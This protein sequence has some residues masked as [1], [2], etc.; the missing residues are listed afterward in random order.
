MPAV[1]KACCN[2]EQYIRMNF[3]NLKFT[4]KKK[5]N[6]AKEKL[7]IYTISFERFFSFLHIPATF[8]FHILHYKTTIRA[9]IKLTTSRETTDCF[10]N[11]QHFLLPAARCAAIRPTWGPAELFRHSLCGSLQIHL[12][13]FTACGNRLAEAWF[14]IGYGSDGQNWTMS[15]ADY[16]R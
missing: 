16:L 7:L 6:Q 3:S 5:K 12:W 15:C 4:K 8:L 10:G 2:V 9:A 11:L 14:T 1:R 13:V